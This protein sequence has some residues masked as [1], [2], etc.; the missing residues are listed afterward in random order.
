[1]NSPVTPTSVQ[2]TN[3]AE[4]LLGYIL[5]SGWEF[6]EILPR[7]GETGAEES[8]GG[9]FSIS[10]LARR[11]NE[12]AFVKVIDVLRALQFAEGTFMER[13][14]SM[15]KSHNFECALLKICQE[16]KMD[17]IVNIFEQGEIKTEPSASLP[18]P[19]PIPYIIFECADGGDIRKA[20]SRNSNLDAA[21]K[22]SILKDVALA[23]QQLHSKRIAHQDLKPSN[24]L[25]FEKD[26]NRAK[27]GDLGRSSIQ[28][29]DAAHDVNNIAGAI[30]YAPPEQAYGIMPE[31]WQDRREGCDL[32]HLG[33]V[34]TFLFSG[35]IA[36]EYYR[37]RV[38]PEILPQSWKGEGL[39]DYET[40]LPN[41]QKVFVEFLGEIQSSFPEWARNEMIEI[42][43]NACTPDYRKRGDPKSRASAGAPIGINTFVSRFDRLSKTAKVKIH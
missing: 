23:L 24:V 33:C 37:L 16:A 32:Y 4:N 18:L 34:I 6:V 3:P 38:S 35:V 2:I 21:W 39:A 7:A 36:N 31:K 8:T 26:G 14:G 5:S 22:F 28:G 17:R 12:T 1:M 20:V 41:L 15:T 42:V 29:M 9:F 30:G 27:V 25:Y 11:G 40:A 19:L 13:M 10:Y 43:T